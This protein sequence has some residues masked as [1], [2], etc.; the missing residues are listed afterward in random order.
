MTKLCDHRH[1]QAG[2]TLVEIAIVMLIV[3]LLLGGLLPVL[4]SQVE[5][6]HRSETRRQ[7]D[8][9][10]QALLGYAVS[11]GYLPC[12]AKSASDGTEDRNVAA[13]T[14][15]KRIGFLPWAELGTSKTDS[16]G[17]MFI[18]SATNNFTNKTPSPLFTLTSLRDITIE[19]R[20]ITNPAAPLINL[21]KASDIPAV[22]LSTGQN[23]IFGTNEYGSPVTSAAP[24]GTHNVD[25]QSQNVTGTV[26][27][28]KWNSFC[29]QRSGR[30]R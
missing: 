27:G 24:A 18:Y 10:Q 30:P 28:T 3:A 15:N 20:D 7:L 19:T 1:K 8:E 2:F 21:T 13:G 5:Q 11:N 17:R 25:D 14:C 29:K 26:G 23:G 4:S 6:Q 9:I 12:P 22:V 16:W